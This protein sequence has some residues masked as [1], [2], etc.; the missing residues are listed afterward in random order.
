MD[1]RFHWLRDRECQVQFCIY[2]CPKNLNYAD[3]WTKHHPA[4]HH[5]SIQREF[6]TPMLVIE[7]LCLS[8]RIRCIAP[9][10]VLLQER[11]DIYKYLYIS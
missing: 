1:M 11:D 9:K 7:M 2:W 5:Q 10:R 4:A 3:Y 6:I 8:H